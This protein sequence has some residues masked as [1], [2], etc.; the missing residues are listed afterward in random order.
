MVKE[1]PGKQSQAEDQEGDLEMSS[2]GIY[3]L[4]ERQV[5]K[6]RGHCYR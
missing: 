2:S 1:E 4:P 6:G 5:D 3:F